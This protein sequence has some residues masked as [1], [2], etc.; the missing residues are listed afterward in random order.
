MYGNSH[1]LQIEKCVEELVL[2]TVLNK[3]INF[4]NESDKSNYKMF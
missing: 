3:K 2:E 1:T 4:K